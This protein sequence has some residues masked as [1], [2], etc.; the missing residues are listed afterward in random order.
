MFKTVLF[1]YK[2]PKEF[3]RAPGL[4]FGLLGVVWGMGGGYDATDAKVWLG[5]VV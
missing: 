3:A 1:G 5:S 4:D 2:R